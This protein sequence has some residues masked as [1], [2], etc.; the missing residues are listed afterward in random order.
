MEYL[1]VFLL[2]ML[3]L[4]ELRGSIP[5]G[6]LILN[7][8]PILVYIVSILGNILIGFF[9]IL[10]LKFL[11]NLLKRFNVINWYFSYSK[12]KVK[13]KISKYGFLGLILF[14]GIPL[15]GTGVYTGVLGSFMLS[16]KI[17]RIILGIIFGSIISAT[18]TTL[19]T[20][21]IG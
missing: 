20:Y 18:I 19:I 16:I 4:I 6:I 7:L 5:F 2:S 3:P 8:N 10:F 14:I 1:K 13:R 12:N 9:L 21:F 15:P 11:F 17:K